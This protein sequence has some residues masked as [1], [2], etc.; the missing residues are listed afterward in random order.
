[1]KDQSPSGITTT[2]RRFLAMAAAAVAV[3]ASPFR[4]VLGQAPAKYLRRNISAPGFP[5]QVLKSYGN[6]ISAMLKL[7]PSDPATGTGMRSSIRSIA[8]TET[9]GSRPGTAAIWDGLSAPAAISPP[10]PT[11]RCRSGTGL[12][13]RASRVSSSKAS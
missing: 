6:A 13:S 10:I 2:R 4:S 8:P 11:L 3:S 7:S 5:A 12:H 9:G 1:M